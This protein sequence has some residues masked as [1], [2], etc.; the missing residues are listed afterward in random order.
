VPREQ[1]RALVELLAE[2]GDPNHERAALRY[3]RRYLEEAD[4]ALADV[5]QIGGLLA[6]RA[7]LIR[8]L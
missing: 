2:K 3:L 5:V 4:P 6:E 7:L 1:A 8:G